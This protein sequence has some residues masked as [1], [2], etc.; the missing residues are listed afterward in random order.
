M[1]DQRIVLWQRIAHLREHVECRRDITN[2]LALN[3]TKTILIEATQPHGVTRAF[4]SHDAR[5]LGR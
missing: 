4:L 5:N 2:G 3:D 1:R